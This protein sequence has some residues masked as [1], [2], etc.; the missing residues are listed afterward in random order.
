MKGI[1]WIHIEAPVVLTNIEIEVKGKEKAAFTRYWTTQEGE[2]PRTVEHQHRH[3]MEKKF[4]H[5]R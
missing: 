3:K 5:Y 2:P 1:I 4:L